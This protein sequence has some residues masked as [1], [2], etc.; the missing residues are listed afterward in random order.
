MTTERATNP[1]VHRAAR[2]SLA[3]VAAAAVVITINHLPV[4][5]LRALGLG[6]GLLGA[7]T[8]LLLR[9]RARR[10]WPALAGYLLV[11]L[12]IVAGFGL[13]KG[14]W[15][16][17]LPLYLGT[18]LSWLSP[19][20]PRP[21]VHGYLLETSGVTMFIASLFVATSAL[22]LVRAVR[23]RPPRPRIPVWG[24]VVASVVLIAG[25]AYADQ[26][27]W[28]PPAGG[29][30]R[31]G[32]LVPTSGPY[33]LLG[34]SFVKAVE[35]ARDDLPPTKYR[36]ELIVRDPGP[37][38][39]RARAV[40]E[41][42]IR[43]D[44]LDAILGGIS[45]IGQVTQPLATRA[46]I[47]HTCVC[48]VAAIGDGVY[49]FTNIPSPEAEG[50][51]WVEEARRRGIRRVAVITQDYPSINNHVAAMEQEA[52]RSGLTI[53]F[54]RRFPDGAPDFPAVIAEA[55]ATSPDVYYVE[56]LPPHLDRLAAALGA[57]GIHD[58]S[59]VV[60]PSLSDI[61]ALFE[62]AWYTDSNLLDP[63][64]KQRFQQR[65]PGV[66][67]A[68]HMMP[69]AYDSLRMLVDAFEAGQNPA[70]HL[71]RL[72]SYDGTADRLTKEP[73]SGNFQSEPAVWV[74]RDGKPALATQTEERR[75]P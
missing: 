68:T 17:A 75:T 31:I 74:I 62:G 8:V 4:L 55:R 46:R 9:Y 12:W 11:N 39:A 27:R 71:R 35:M 21:T 20:F 63:S 51:R 45:L 53:A 29:V 16:G 5:G 30:V 42:A 19:A 3:S 57:A 41:D 25:Y 52:R 26:D 7:A 58:I 23:A 70:V 38:P 14:L 61:P 50:K 65:Y 15:Q 44:R 47:P 24:A 67:F 73:G 28:V 1:D 49:N 6:A 48:T 13:W 64:F 72:T 66:R 43:S 18:F 33:A 56:A 34:G 22:R 32:V 59:S 60:A 37:D 36:Y 54:D 2:A 69:Y 40:I 10:R